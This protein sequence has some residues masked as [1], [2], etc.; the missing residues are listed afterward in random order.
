[1]KIDTIMRYVKNRK[2]RK[3]GV[4]VAKEADKAV[5]I[6]WSLCHK[7]DKF[8]KESGI[9]QAVTKYGMPIPP[10]LLQAMRDFRVQCFLYFKEATQIQQPVVTSHSRQTRKVRQPA[11]NSGHRGGCLYSPTDIHAPCTCRELAKTVKGGKEIR[12]ELATEWSRWQYD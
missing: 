2:G 8:S 10:S 12:D 4:L 7:K 11:R 1:M 5:R 6:G 9:S 3:V